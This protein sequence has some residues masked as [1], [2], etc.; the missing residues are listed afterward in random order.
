MA[1]GLKTIVLDTPLPRALAEF[2]GELLGWRIGHD[3]P[4]WVV[5]V[6]PDGGTNIACQ[7]DPD[8]QPT[9][10]PGRERPQM[11]HLDLSVDDMSR[12]HGRALGL[13]ARLLDTQGSFRV[14]ADPAGHTFCL[15]ACPGQ[16]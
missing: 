12:E 8:F 10:W 3:E 13:G 4:D 1:V 9:T 11:L 7:L 5:V 2:Y 14:Y 16:L 15:C 6:N